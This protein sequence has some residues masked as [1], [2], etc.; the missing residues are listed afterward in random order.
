MTSRSLVLVAFG[1]LQ[2]SG[3]LASGILLQA[4]AECRLTVDGKPQ[5]ILAPHKA[6]QLTLALGEH[7]IEAIAVTGE[8][9]WSKTIAVTED[10]R[11]QELSIALTGFAHTGST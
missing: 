1:L 11:D 7:H 6:L 9:K 8:S 2:S 4:D 10:R 5:G 3:L